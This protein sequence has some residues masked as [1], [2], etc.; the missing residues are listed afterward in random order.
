[1]KIVVIGD[2]HFGGGYALG[3]TDPNTRLNTRLLDFSNTFDYVVDYMMNNGVRHFFI[4]G[5]VFEH[6]RPQASELSLFSKKIYKLSELGIHTYIVIGNHDLIKEQSATTLDVLSSL[7]LPMLHI[8][9][10][11]EGITIKEE[12]D[13][14]NVIFIPFRTREMLDCNTNDEAVG[15]VSSFLEYEVG[16]FGNGAPILGIGHLMIQG[17]MI[18]NA[19]LEASPGEVVL[20]QEIFKKF[21]G[22]V[23]GHVHPHM[24]VRKNPFLVHLGSMECKDF[25][26]ARH[27]KYFASI[28]VNK[29]L[30][31]CFESLPT[32]PLFEL[33]SDQSKAK[34]GK[35]VSLGVIEYLKSFNNDLKDSIIRLEIL[36]NEKCLYDLD[37]E[38]IKQ[39]LKQN[40]KIHYCSGIYPQVVSKRQL[41]KSTI[42]EHND[43]IA[44]FNDY[45][46]LEEDLVIREKMKQIGEKIIQEKG[47][48]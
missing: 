18:G 40:N 1:M 19:V 14:L 20:S 22:V 16:K 37:K 11:I 8:F 46:Q 29:T 34:S 6:R 23:M 47:K 45:I 32:R 42:T 39:H 26:E 44:S 9:T 13:L 3:R 30:S 7:Q 31:Y 15:R 2:L 5:D 48:I 12:D 4:T 21:D 38:I 43:P 36:I 27:K 17:T 41:R 28:D 25:G 33:V 35:E 24:I 10:D